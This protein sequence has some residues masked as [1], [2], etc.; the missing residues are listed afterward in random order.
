M[1]RPHL[2]FNNKNPSNIEH[3]NAF[4]FLN[5]WYQNALSS[6]QKSNQHVWE[7]TNFGL[8]GVVNDRV[9]IPLD[10]E[11]AGNQTFCSCY[12]RKDVKPDRLIGRVP[13]TTF[14]A[15]RSTPNV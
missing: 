12:L 9:M 13:H 2:F 8:D 1:C 3:P 14:K 15:S 10:R 4:N 6:N 5:A 11:R 7:S